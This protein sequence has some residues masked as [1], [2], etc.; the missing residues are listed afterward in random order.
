MASPR[1]RK[2]LKEVR[3]QDE[4]NVSMT[5]GLVSV[6]VSH[7][8]VAVSLLREAGHGTGDQLVPGAH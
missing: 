7:V 5:F 6:L 4:N 2:V 3:A 8:A 1:T